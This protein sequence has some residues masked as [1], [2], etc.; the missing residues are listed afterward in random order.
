MAPSSCFLND[1]P[2]SF[3]VQLDF[4]NIFD[5]LLTKSRNELL[6]ANTFNFIVKT[7]GLLDVGIKP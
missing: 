3:V 1:A 5:N 6:E 2:I 4:N 7:K